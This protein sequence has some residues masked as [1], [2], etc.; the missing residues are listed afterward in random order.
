MLKGID[1]SEHQGVIDWNKVKDHIDF[2][3][4]RTGYG[5][6]NIDKQFIRNIEE[7]NRLGIKVGVYWFSY[8]LN[9]EM[10]SK[11]AEY[12][13]EAIKP[14]K[15]N[16]PVIF[17][18]EYD[19]FN[20]ASKNGITLDKRTAT[21]MV[22]AF[23]EKIESNGYIAVNYANPNF[24]EDEFY[25]EE[26]EKYPLWLAWYGVTEES[27]KKYNPSI[28]Q[29]S[30]SGEIEGIEGK[31][32][33]MNYC[34]KEFP[35]VVNKVKA[36]KPVQVKEL[37]EES[38]EGQEV[39]ELQEELNKQF[40]TGLRVDGLF[41]LDTLNA[42]VTVKEGARGNLTRLI[43]QRLL[44]RGYTSLNDTGADGIF[45]SA[46]KQAI[47]NLQKNKELSVDGVV[48]KDTW[49]ALYSK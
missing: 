1:V 10:A 32:V 14:Y 23:L 26:L 22:K 47:M 27:I 41:G 34:Y 9:V 15:I 3:I 46:T 30:E 48:G 28:W 44:N 17:D 39:K 37:W 45:G 16:F 25:Q 2:A 36:A 24:I 8:A 18:L 49:K 21:D 6:N 35:K 19:S 11:E 4:L 42:C 31:E 43:Q 13:L 20:Y 29:Y 12:C 40:N 38:I 7:C 33:D 5:R